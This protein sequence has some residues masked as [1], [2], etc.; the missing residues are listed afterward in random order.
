[1][2]VCLVIERNACTCNP[3]ENFVEMIVL[4]FLD[5][6]MVFLADLLMQ[7]FQG[8]APDRSPQRKRA[9]LNGL[10]TQANFTVREG[11]DV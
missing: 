4:S 10:S 9:L 5:R 3:T 2:K 8:A 1:M 7:F 6:L 11:L